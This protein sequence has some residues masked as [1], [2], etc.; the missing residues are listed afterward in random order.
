MNEQRA[1]Q[2]QILDSD[3]LSEVQ[4]DIYQVT[5]PYLQQSVKGSF[6]SNSQLIT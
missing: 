5:Y 6:K 3:W 1:S 4:D 2:G